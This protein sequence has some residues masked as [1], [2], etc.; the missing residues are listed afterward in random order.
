MSGISTRSGVSND[1]S[2]GLTTA[3]QKSAFG[4][5]TV[6]TVTNAAAA[7]V[8]GTTSPTITIDSAGTYLIMARARFEMVG[9]TFIASR[10]LTLKLNRTNNSPADLPNATVLYNTPTATTLTDTLTELTLQTIYTTANSD[11]VVVLSTLIGTVPS[12]GSLTVNE[13]SLIAIRLQQ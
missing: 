2:D 3:N 6:Y 1:I 5:G 4:T 13:C 12:A 9:A 7:I 11:D 8:Q 10:L